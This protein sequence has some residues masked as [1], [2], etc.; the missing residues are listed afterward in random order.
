[1]HCSHSAQQHCQTIIS[2]LKSHI[3]LVINHH[4][5]V[6]HFTV[7]CK[8][9]LTFDQHHVIFLSWS[10]SQ[11]LLHDGVNVASPAQ[12]ASLQAKDLQ[13]I[14]VPLGSGHHPGQVGHLHSSPSYTHPRCLYRRQCVPSL[15]PLS[16]PSAHPVLQ[17]SNFCLQQPAQWVN[18]R[19]CN[20]VS[21]AMSDIMLLCTDAM[22]NTAA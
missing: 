21:H 2:S 11:I 16:S 17:Q 8:V 19:R 10:T 7:T 14:Q 4:Y 6:H 9:L 5:Y 3:D 1:M 20:L 12:C 22:Q 13:L 15:L 18:K